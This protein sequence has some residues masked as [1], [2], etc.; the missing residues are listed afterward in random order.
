MEP[1]SKQ[2]Q[3]E[4]S[5]SGL[6]HYRLAK[7]AGISESAISRFMAGNN[8][9]SL[10][11]LNGIAYALGLKIEAGVSLI[12]GSSGNFVATEFEV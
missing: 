2:I 8:S 11:T 6:S 3:D 7:L 4:I 12:N 1:F 10:K 9:M 5:N